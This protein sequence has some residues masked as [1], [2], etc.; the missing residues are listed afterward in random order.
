V[1]QT[2]RPNEAFAKAN[3]WSV[4]RTTFDFKTLARGGV[5]DG[6]RDYQRL[7]DHAEYFRK[8]RASV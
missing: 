7:V 4:S 2:C 1:T 8:D 3:G 5:H 6:A